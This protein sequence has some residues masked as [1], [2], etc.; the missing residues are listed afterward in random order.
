MS[1]LNSDMIRSIVL[2]SWKN[3]MVKCLCTLHMWFT[4][5][6][7]STRTYGMTTCGGNTKATS[8]L[9]SFM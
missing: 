5:C 4:Y 8:W 9:V 1:R 7:C 3:T 2:L 6:N